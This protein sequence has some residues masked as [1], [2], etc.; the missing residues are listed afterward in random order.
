MQRLEHA[1]KR[2]KVGTGTPID[3]SGTWKNELGSTMQIEQ[4]GDSVTGTYRSAV[5][6]KGG[7]TSG[8]LI[9]YVDGDLI[10]FVVHWDQF[11]AIT[12]WVGQCEPGTS[13]DRINTLWQMTQQVEA[14]EEWASINAGADTFV[15]V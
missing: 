9:G 2:V 5:S 8:D 14:G 1:L 13:N 7:S 10:A 3:F 6:E 12:A 15:R 4:S 11:Q